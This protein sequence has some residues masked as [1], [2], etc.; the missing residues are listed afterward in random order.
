MALAPQCLRAG[1][2]RVSATASPSVSSVAMWFESPRWVEQR[3]D[4][5]I[6]HDD[7][8]DDWRDVLDGVNDEHRC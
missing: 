6:C 4:A 3:N 2:V 1:R 5:P 8:R 7:A